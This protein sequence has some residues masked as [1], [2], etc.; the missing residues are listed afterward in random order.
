MKQTENNKY[1]KYR[2]N[3][4]SLAGATYTTVSP[5]TWGMGPFD[6]VTKPPKDP[7]KVRTLKSQA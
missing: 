2:L 7:G 6:S 1:N 3:N 4:Y 5:T